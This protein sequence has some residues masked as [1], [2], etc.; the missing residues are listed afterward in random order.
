MGGKH[1]GKRRNCSWRAISP[2]P[3]V[4]FKRLVSQGHQK[5]VIVWEFKRFRFMSVYADCLGF[6]L[7]SL[8]HM[9]ILGSSNSAANENVMWK[10]LNKWDTIIWL[11][12]KHCGKRRNCSLRAISSFPIMFS[13]TVC[14]WCDKMSIYGIKGYYLWLRRTQTLCR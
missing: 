7:N 10:K 11:S 9:S 5:G 3:T 2:F 14:C 1:C 12:R 13:K 6:I 8:P 4:F